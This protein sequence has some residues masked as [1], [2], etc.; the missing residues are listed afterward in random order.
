M[1]LIHHLFSRLLSTEIH[2]YTHD[3]FVLI[4]FIRL[5]CQESIGLYW[6]LKAILFLIYQVLVLQLDNKG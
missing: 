1:W 4:E 3:I 2:I 6:I 5:S